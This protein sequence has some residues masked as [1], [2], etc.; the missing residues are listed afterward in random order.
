MKP[1][2]DKIKNQLKEMKFELYTLVQGDPEEKDFDA[3]DFQKS[4]QTTGL[5]KDKSLSELS[6]SFSLVDIEASNLETLKSK[7]QLFLV[8]SVREFLIQMLFDDSFW[9]K[10]I[11]ADLVSKDFP[12]VERDDI[13]SGLL[14]QEICADLSILCKP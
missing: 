11:T 14:L 3:F 12:N 2:I 10:E 7:M 5:L 1:V 9:A 8:K 13:P 4:A 6:L